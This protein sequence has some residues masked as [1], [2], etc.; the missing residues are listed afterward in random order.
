[1]EVINILEVQTGL[2]IGL[3]VAAALRTIDYVVHLYRGRKQAN[4]IRE[5]IEDRLRLILNPESSVIRSTEIGKIGVQVTSTTDKLDEARYTYFNHM[6]LKL[7][8]ALSHCS[9]DLSYDRKVSIYHF[10]ETNPLVIKDWR[11][12]HSIPPPVEIYRAITVDTLKKIEW[13]N[14]RIELN[15]INT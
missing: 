1:M 6:I 2:V 12:N 3:A 5:I 11:S 4:L 13:L 8:L 9:S 15:N 7:R 14:L 10:L